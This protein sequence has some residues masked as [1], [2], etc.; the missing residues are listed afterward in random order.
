M[1]I[2]ERMP[3]IGTRRRALEMKVAD[4]A[5]ALGVTPQT[6]YDWEKGKYVPSGAVLPAIAELLQCEIVD[7]YEDG[8]TRAAG[9]GAQWVGGGPYEETEVTGDDTV[10]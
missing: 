4:A 2:Y 8:E 9:L 1:K 7:L 6:W 10:T 3:G 5:A